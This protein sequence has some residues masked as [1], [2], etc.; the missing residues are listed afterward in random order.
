[1]K[2]SLCKKIKCSFLGL[3]LISVMFIQ[4]CDRPPRRGVS[5]VMENAFDKQNIIPLVIIGSGA[6]GLS[7]A[8][9]GVWGNVKTLVVHGPLP[10]GLLTQTSL[11]ENWPGSRSILG[12]DIIKN[13]QDQSTNL[14]KKFLKNKVSAIEF[15][16]DT[17]TSADLSQWPFALETSGGETIHAL[18]L[19]VATGATP[20]MLGVPGE[21]E[22]WKMGVTTCAVCDGPFYKDKNVVVIGG[23][24]S[25]VEEAI[26]LARHAKN[27]TVLVRKESMKAAPSMQAHLSEYPSIKV[28]YSVDVQRII[29]DESGVTGV[30]IKDA[31]TKE[32]TT[33]P[34]S[35]VFLAIG[36]T[37]NS[38]LVRKY[39]QT[40]ADGY[41]VLKGRN[42]ETSVHGVFSAGDVEDRVYRQ[43]GVA[44]GHGIQ[45][46]LDAVAFL[47]S[48]GF[49]NDVA[50]KLGE[51]LY[52]VKGE[53]TVQVLESI[54][55]FVTQVEQYK[56]LAVIECMMHECPS[57]IMLEPVIQ[58]AAQHV[59]EGIRY[60]RVDTNVAPDLAEK[61]F[62]YQVPS[63]LV[64]RDGTLVARYNGAM[65]D[66]EFAVFMEK[67]S[68]VTG[69]ALPAA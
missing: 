68:S 27:I 50:A 8:I 45:A 43:A 3:L 47:T 16:Q 23:G 10:G 2:T 42:Q 7:A 34:V 51:S 9:Y 66:A 48:I 13:L 38:D 67:F 19:I 31:K 24:D 39:V 59:T 11:V 15:L 17:I 64:Y 37:P 25:A 61:L 36:H 44:S 46:A 18:S 41:I 54:D 58:R 20:K 57:C 52:R 4:G 69:A 30:E 65:N 28:I 63:I 62:V 29:G 6:A 12:Q 26:Q 40:D 55:E 21:Q 33:L 49:N 60:F 22:F 5:I 56:G 14:G 35:G 32:V 1:M 53:G